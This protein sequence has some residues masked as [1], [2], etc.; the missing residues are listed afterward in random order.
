MVSAGRYRPVPRSS[1]ALRTEKGDSQG[2]IGRTPTGRPAGGEDELLISCSTPIAQVTLQI[3][4]PREIAP[5]RI[6]S[7][8]ATCSES[9]HRTDEWVGELTQ[10][11][12]VRN[13]LGL[14]TESIKLRYILPPRRLRCPAARSLLYTVGN[15]P[16]KKYIILSG[17]LSQE[18]REYISRVENYPKETRE[19]FQR[20]FIASS[21]IYSYQFFSRTSGA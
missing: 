19:M 4:R 15:Y 9:K 6:P 16:E 18:E 7:G 10:I 17:K 11:S 14:N 21:F 12:V 5:P 2:A 20:F 3:T 8:R 13:S 1:C